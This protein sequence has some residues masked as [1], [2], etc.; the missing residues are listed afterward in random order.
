MAWYKLFGT[1]EAAC[2]PAALK[3]GYRNLMLQYHPD[4]LSAEL[5]PCAQQAAVIVGAGNELL[6]PHCTR[7]GGEL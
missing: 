2:T 6:K 3:K 7:R 1:S 4:K 5:R